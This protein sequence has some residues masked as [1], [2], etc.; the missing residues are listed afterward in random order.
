[1]IKSNLIQSLLVFSFLMGTFGIRGVSG[2]SPEPEP[3][4]EI[5]DTWEAYPAS[6]YSSMSV[7]LSTPTHQVIEFNTGEQTQKEQK[8]SQEVREIP[9]LVLN[10]NGV[11]TPGYER[12]L[13]VVANNIPVFAPGIRVILTISTQHQDPDRA[14]ADGKRIQVWRDE[15]FIP[16]TSQTQ[17]GVRLS[18]S[19]TFDRHTILDEKPII[20][21]TDYFRYQI[22]VVDLNGNL[23]QSYTQDYA[24]L[25]ENHWRVP[26]PKL[27]EA[28][29]G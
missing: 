14:R 19:V 27:L 3:E 11:L 25:M 12:T 9:Q 22:S 23:R 13:E 4:A 15:Q 28:E 21:P 18:F 16:Y 8:P 7:E 2:S 5:K 6:T 1:M 24:F 10:R 29:E 20:T 17:Q 26:L